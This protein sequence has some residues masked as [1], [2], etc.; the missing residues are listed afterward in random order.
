VTLDRKPLGDD[1]GAALVTVL[2]MVAVLST[3]ALAMMETS[4]FSM[5]RTANQTQMDQARWY[6]FG[7]EAYA[8]RLVR[9]LTALD[10]SVDQSQWQGRPFTY[11]LD[12]GLMT[13]TL[14][15]GSNCF[16]LNSLLSQDEDGAFAADATG[17]IQLAR[18]FDL[19]GIRIDGTG[20]ALVAAI[21]DWID[22]D[23]FPGAGGAEDEA[24]ASRGA[25]YRPG[26]TLFA[27]VSEVERIAGVD[28]SALRQLGDLVCVRP[29][30]ARN[31]LNINTLQIDD[32]ALLA[33]AISGDL[34]LQAAEDVIRDRP[35][36]GWN[37]IDAFFS[38]PRLAG[39]EVTEQTKALFTKTSRY[40]VLVARV[41][42]GGSVETSASLIEAI[43]APV[44]VRRVFGVGD[45]GRSL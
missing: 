25:T 30:N 20:R 21:A 38:H 44:V 41:Q 37:S 43:G 13:L 17:Q 2:I 36:G 33:A 35:A 4:R 28:P 29:T 24:Y 23:T 10:S 45:T 15:D 18:I 3:L 7:A 6:V 8:L 11:P 34:S 19:R 14:W 1:R 31:Q 9:D 32:A 27:D 26:N 12:D 42:H 39:R 5:R 16:N 22:P 40:Y